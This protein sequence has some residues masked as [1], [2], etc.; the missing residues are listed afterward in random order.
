MNLLTLGANNFNITDFCNEMQDILQII[1][2]ILLIFKIAIPILIIALGMFDF[3]KAV[4]AEKEDEVKK[5]A[6]RLIFRI[7]AGIV[8]F[9]IPNIV[10]FIFRMIGQYNED[11]GT[12]GDN[13]GFSICE[14]CILHPRSGCNN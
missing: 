12:D 3:G 4:V 5:Q 9:L 7:I 6:K 10:L 1:G 8:I 14:N 13:Q 2:W 11:R